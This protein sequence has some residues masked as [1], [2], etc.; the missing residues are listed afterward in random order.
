LQEEQQR[1]AAEAK[2]NYWYPGEF[3]GVRQWQWLEAVLLDI[4]LMERR[5]VGENNRR[6]RPDTVLGLRTPKF[7]TVEAKQPPAGRSEKPEARARVQRRH[8]RRMHPEKVVVRR[9]DGSINANNP[10]SRWKR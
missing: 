8:R 3:N 9:P 6:L 7:I 4:T 1:N 2:A 5:H 10:T